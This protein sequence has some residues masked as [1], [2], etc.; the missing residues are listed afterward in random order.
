[1]LSLGEKPLRAREHNIC[2]VMFI[3]ASESR[4]TAKPREP[5]I[6]ATA[7]TAARRTTFYWR[8]DSR[9]TKSL[10]L[11]TSPASSAASELAKRIADGE[12]EADLVFEKPEFAAAYHR[13]YRIVSALSRKLKEKKMTKEAGAFL[14]ICARGKK[15]FKTTQPLDLVMK[16]RKLL[17]LIWADPAVSKL[18]AIRWSNWGTEGSLDQNMKVKWKDFQF[19]TSST[20]F[21]HFS[22]FQPTDCKCE[23][24]SVTK[25]DEDNVRFP[26]T[27]PEDGYEGHRVF[28][29]EHFDDI[30][31]TEEQLFNGRNLPIP[32]YLPQQK[33]WALLANWTVRFIF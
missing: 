12:N 11:T 17:F 6:C 33:H 3:F 25:R 31:Q 26:S 13:Y 27:E 5:A 24:L 29:F 10:K 9:P 2:S 1:M 14:T 18:L 19:H 20:D 23:S 30:R 32:Q 8:W 28:V 15:S 22:H 4:L 7:S 21:H 16:E